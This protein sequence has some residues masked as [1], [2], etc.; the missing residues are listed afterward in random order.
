MADPQTANSIDRVNLVYESK[1]G[2]KTVEVELPFRL[3]VLGD[4]T[5]DEVSSYFDEQ[6]PVILNEKSSRL[7][8]LFK[9]FRP[10]LTLKLANRLQSDDSELVADLKFE[11][12]DDFMPEQILHQ[13][14]WLE[15][16]Q[17]FSDLLARATDVSTIELPEQ[18]RELIE[19]VLKA[20]DSSL[21]ALQQGGESMG[22]LISSIESRLCEQLDEILHHPEF[23]AMESTWR[24]LSFLID[25]TDF[26][27]NCEIA[28]VNISKQGLADDF[29]DVP[30]VTHSQYYKLVYSEEYGQFG[31]RPY[32]TIIAD[33]LFNP[34]APDIKLLQRLA[35]VSAVAHAPFIAAASAEF[36]DIENYSD[37]SRLRDLSAIFSQPAYAKWNSFRESPDSRYVGLTLPSFLL[38]EAYELNIGGMRYVES[39]RDKDKCLI[40]GNAAFALATRLLDSFARYRW[41][42]NCTGNTSGQV[43][44]LGMK[45]GKIPTRFILADRRESDVVAQGFIPLSVHKGDETAA[46]YSAYSTHLVATDNNKENND[47]SERLAS[48]LPYLLIVSRIS[49]YLK[50]IQRENL[51]TWRNRLDL[52]KQLNKWLSQYISDMDNPA[53]G[54]R[55]RRPLRRAEIKVREIEGKQDWFVVGIKITPHLKFMGSSFELSEISKMEKN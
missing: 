15:K 40:W 23:N 50:V 24:S 25:R 48:Q 28:V 41:C 5:R 43:E 12:L 1:V 21:Q 29:E 38:R 35:S 33:Y 52:D 54:V 26:S 51:G 34:S 32:G 18:D 37:F 49:Q 20:D 3:L 14:P 6:Q 2:D 8:T 27:E 9:K 36:F 16:I 31:G 10:A 46:F 30:E 4:F 53:A 55:A 7:D 39:V 13:I 11:K 45:N 47:I 42:L 17:Q 44:G 22:W 19:S